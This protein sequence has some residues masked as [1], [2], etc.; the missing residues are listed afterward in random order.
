M[1][2]FFP[3]VIFSKLFLGCPSFIMISVKNPL[4]YILHQK[5]QRQYNAKQII[6]I[7][8]LP[9]YNNKHG[10]EFEQGFFFHLTIHHP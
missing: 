5:K 1:T 10:I 8:Y 3:K 9:K 6:T 7:L 2:P 4:N